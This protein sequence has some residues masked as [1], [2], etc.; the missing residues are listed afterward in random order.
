[1]SQNVK[2]QHSYQFVL[3]QLNINQ[4]STHI[5]GYRLKN[6]GLWVTA[7]TSQILKL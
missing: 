1:M 3:K 4:S 7:K 6:V 2:V 5:K